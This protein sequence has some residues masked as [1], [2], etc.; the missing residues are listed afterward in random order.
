MNKKIIVAIDGP[1]GSGKSTVARSVAERLGYTYIDT[2]AMY[3]AVALWALRSDI[4]LDDMH[5]LQ[6]L[7]PEARIEFPGGRVLLN[8]E[9]V[10]D[11]IRTPEVSSAASKVAI[12]PGVRKAMRAEQRRIGAAGSAVMEGRD[13]GTVVFPDAQV[14]VF[15][16]A[17][18]EERAK[19]R[20]EEL[21]EPVG[22]VA[23]ELNQRDHQD[24]T[25]AEAPLTQAPDAEYVDTTGLTIPQVEEVVLQ[26][27]R[28][29]TTNGGAHPA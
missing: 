28:K 23:R 1:A 21:G 14:K 3:R 11:A 4:D 22:E 12:Y 5:R 13:I 19:R 25:R 20:A 10:T 15:L 9:D 6:Q 16:D 26:L 27:V 17:R 24:R 2:G 18:P 7:A 8:G 29:R